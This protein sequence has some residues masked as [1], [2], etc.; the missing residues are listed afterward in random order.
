MRVSRSFVGFA[1][2]AGA[3]P[4][5][6]A[7]SRQGPAVAP[8]GAKGKLVAR[9]S[10]PDEGDGETFRFPEDKGGRLLARLLAPPTTLPAPRPQPRPRPTSKAV[11]QPALPLPRVVALPRVPAEETS[12]HACAPTTADAG[13][14]P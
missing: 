4:F 7:G 14:G 12:A 10:G 1:F 3:L 8:D 9:S 2:L 6:L 5:F 11:E 13:A